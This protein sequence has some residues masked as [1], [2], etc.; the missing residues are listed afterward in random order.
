M[1]R[2]I[3]VA[4]ADLL[5]TLG[6]PVETPRSLPPT[7][8]VRHAVHPY[9]HDGT[10]RVYQYTIPTACG[11]VFF[12]NKMNNDLR[13]YDAT[14]AA[15]RHA[16]DEYIQEHGPIREGYVVLRSW[17]WTG[18]FTIT[19]NKNEDLLILRLAEPVLR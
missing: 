12:Y 19:E 15:L 4:V 9:I 5:N 1:L 3:S 6:R 2:S 8:L 17:D 18:H 7:F 11:S 14:S 16:L 10:G 13:G